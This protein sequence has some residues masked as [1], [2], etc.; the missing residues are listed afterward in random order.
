MTITSGQIAELTEGELFGSADVVITGV[1]PLEDAEEGSLSF[2]TEEY[3]KKLK[4]IDTKASVLII[5][6]SL[7]PIEGKVC[8]AVE[9]PME[10][11][12]KVLHLFEKKHFGYG[13]SP[14]AVIYPN[15]TIGDNVIIREFVVIEDGAF[16]EDDVVIM[17]F[18]YIGRNVRVGRKS[19]L[20]PAVVIY[21]GCVIGEKNI[22]HAGAVIGAD[23]FGYIEKNGV[24]V[25]IPQVGNVVI[26]DNVEIGANTCIDRATLGSTKI[27]AG[28]KIDNLV[29]I[30]HN[31]C[32]GDNTVMAGQCGI[33]GSV[34]IGKNVMMGGQVGVADHVNI[35]DNV[36]IAAK[37]GV[38]GN[39]RD[40]ETVIGSP[41]MPVAVW[42][43]IYGAMKKLPEIYEFYKK[44]KKQGVGK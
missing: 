18:C 34:R 23:G 8:I 37:S 44:L 12:I 19:I 22:I 11:L 13:I 21:H 16:I 42:R 27:G 32:V 43:K 2:V 36:K 26:G 24:R 20:F 30:G 35:G 9:N 41:A 3:A 6:K 25:K 1:Y 38:P 5:P 40:G 33:A 4:K 7:S 10:A 31:V 29:Q 28:V 39:I 17:P 15:V 14:H